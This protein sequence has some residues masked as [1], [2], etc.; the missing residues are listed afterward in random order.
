MIRLAARIGIL[1]AL[2]TAPC[3]LPA[4]AQQA[5]DPATFTSLWGARDADLANRFGDRL[6]TL[7]GRFD[8]G[9]KLY[10]ERRLDGVEIGGVPFAAYLQMDRRTGQLQQVLLE[11][12]QG[13]VTPATTRQALDALVEMLGEPA[14]ESVGGDPRTPSTASFTWRREGTTIQVSLFDFHTTGIFF[15]D[16]DP[17]VRNPLI[18]FYLRMRNDP[19]FL[20][21]R[22]LVRMHPSSRTDLELPEPPRRSR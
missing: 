4:R 19:R 6:R 14:A 3:T 16:P 10:A 15:E 21:R 9:P 8:F 17:A 12:R 7:P 20:P 13:Q 2:V 5:F 1:L 18:P 11:R 22:L